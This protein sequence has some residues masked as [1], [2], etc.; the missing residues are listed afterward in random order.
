MEAKPDKYYLVNPKTH[1]FQNY[2]F[3]AINTKYPC[4]EYIIQ[5]LNDMIKIIQAGKPADTNL[6]TI[7]TPITLLESQ[8]KF[9]PALINGLKN[10]ERSMYPQMPKCCPSSSRNIKAIMG[11]AG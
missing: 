6:L 10:L 5:A 9:R 2:E 3:T 1:Q 4:K 8:K 11:F 7:F